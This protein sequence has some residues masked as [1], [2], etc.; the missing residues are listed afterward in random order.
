V[1]ATA[2]HQPNAAVTYDIAGGL[3]NAHQMTSALVPKAQL[4]PRAPSERATGSAM[5]QASLVST[6]A[7]P[8]RR[9]LSFRLRVTGV[10]STRAAKTASGVYARI[11]VSR[12]VSRAPSPPSAESKTDHSFTSGLRRS[13]LVGVENRALVPSATTNESTTTLA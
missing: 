12:T 2:T 5:A 8:P 4:G 3:M 11:R 1:T 7:P 10:A 9:I 6:I 13:T